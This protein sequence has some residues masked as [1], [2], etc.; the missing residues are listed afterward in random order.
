MLYSGFERTLVN[1]SMGKSGHKN[2][3][4]IRVTEKK[5]LRVMWRTFNIKA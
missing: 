1:N 3:K 5:H 2:L 4:E